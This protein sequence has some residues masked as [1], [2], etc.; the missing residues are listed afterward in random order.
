MAEV[1]TPAWRVLAT[2]IDTTALDALA[3][4]GRDVTI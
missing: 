4:P 2:D 3:A 1:G